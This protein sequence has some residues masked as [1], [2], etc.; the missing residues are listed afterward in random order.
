[1]SNFQSQGGAPALIVADGDVADGPLL[2]AAL[3][4]LTAAGRPLVVAADG[5]ALKAERLGLVPDVVVGDL[6][7]LSSTV[8]GTLRGAGLEVYEH[9]AQK[10]QSDTELAVRE[11]LRR[12]SRR[13]VVLAALGGQRPDHALA[14]VLLLTLPELAECEAVLLDGPST[15]RVLSGPPASE[16]VLRGQAGDLV[17]L[18]PL[19]PRVEGI[20]TQGLAYALA[21]EALLQGPTR[22]LSNVLDA[23]I[24]SVRV[25][26]G[27]LAIVHTRLQDEAASNA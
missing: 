11:A 18:L 10:E 2:R 4:E 26:S 7:S 1:M 15:L 20:R 14:N 23:P 5:G 21:D 22:G 17:S 24:A 25:E 27:R 8:A 16:V 13:I 19:T 9:P 12:G 3:A 6:D